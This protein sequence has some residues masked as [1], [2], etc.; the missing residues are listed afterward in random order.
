H[1][2]NFIHTCERL[3]ERAKEVD[4]ENILRDALMANGHGFLYRL[5][6]QHQ[7]NAPEMLADIK[8]TGTYIDF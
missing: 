6:K 4:R 8:A 1:T 2:N 3:L 7:A 5:M